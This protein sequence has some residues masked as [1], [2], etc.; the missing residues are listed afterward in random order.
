MPHRQPAARDFGAHFLRQLQQPHV[1]G[2]RRSILA[3]GLGNFF[4]RHVEVGAQLLVRGGLIDGIEIFALDVFDERHLEQLRVSS[5]GHLLDDDRYPR[6][7][8]ALRGA[9]AALAGDDAIAIGDLADHDRL[10]D[11]VGP[12]GLGQL[13]EACVLEAMTRLMLVG[14]NPIDV[15]FRRGRIQ[16]YFRHV[17]NER[18]ESFSK[19]GT[20]LHR[21]F[22]IASNSYSAR[23]CAS[24]LP[25]WICSV[26]RA[27]N[28]RASAI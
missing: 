10:N 13:V 14:R 24:A 7:T 28:S 21:S 6:Q 9:P 12:D 25:R 2:D 18:A 15:H 22:R 19:C 17:G 16:P 20:F 27:R 4:L 26:F 5:S 3:D 23:L 8:R 11:A 1:V